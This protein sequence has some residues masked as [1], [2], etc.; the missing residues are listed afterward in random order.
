MQVR[1][2]LNRGEIAALVIVLMMVLGVAYNLSQSH[3]T[4]YLSNSFDIG[5]NNYGNR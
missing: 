3:E 2:P 5:V 1:K 4:E